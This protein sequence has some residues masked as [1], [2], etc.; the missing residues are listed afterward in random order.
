MT[1]DHCNEQMARLK[2]LRGMPEETFEYFSALQDVPDER[3]TAAVSHALRTRIWYP[4]PAELRLDC[5]ATSN[6][7]PEREE[8]RIEALV[9]GGR[10]VIIVNPLNPKQQIRVKVDRIWKL[11]CNDCEDTGWKSRQCPAAPCG[12]RQGEHGPHEWVERCQCIDWNPT[13]RRRKEAGAKYAQPAEKVH[14]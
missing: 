12:R 1:P 8:S 10:E 13:I 4:T 9:G 11:D 14:A 5:D 7:I 6:R 2:V 3:F